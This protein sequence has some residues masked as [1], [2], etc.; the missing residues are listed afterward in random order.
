MPAT[1]IRPRRRGA[2]QPARA[3]ARLPLT[4]GASDGLARVSGGRPL[5]ELVALT[6]ASAVVVG[7]AEN[8]EEPTVAVSGSAGPVPCR[9]GPAA[10]P[11]VAHLVR[12][13]DAELRS[14]PAPADVPA[15]LAEALLIRSAR[16]GET[17]PGRTSEWDGI[18]LTLTAPAADGSRELVAEAGPERAE[19]WFLEILLRSV[20]Q[21]LAG[22]TEPHGAVADLAPAAPDDIATAIE[23]GRRTFVPD[24]ATTTLVAPIEEAV[25]AHADRPAVV[26]GS[27]TLTYREF[28]QAT[29]GVAARLHASGIGRGDRV[30]VL[31]GKSVHAVPAITG[32]LLAGAAY[33]PLDPRSPAPRLAEILDDAACSVV[34]AAPEL[35]TTLPAGLTAPVIDIDIGAAAGAAAG[36]GAGAGAAV[37][38]TAGPDPDDL[39]YVVYTSGS[40]GKPKGVEVR[41]RAVASYVRW[42]VVN[43][44]FD[45]GTRLLQLPSLAFD[46]SVA[47]LFPVLASG[48]LLVLADTHKLLPR[49]LAELAGQHHV[50][51]LTT[52]PSLYRVLLDDLADAA[53]SLHAVTVAG[54]ATTADLARRHHERLPGVRLINEY[55]PTEN[56]V[57]ATAFDHGPDAGPG[58]PIGHVIPNTVATVTGADGRALPAGFVGELRL[59]GHGLADGY[60]NRPDLTAEAFVADA[61]APGGRSYRTG[62]LVWWRPDGMLE[63]AGRADDQVK[64]RGHRVEPGE[65]ESVLA[66]LPGVSQ[67]AVAVVPGPDGAPSLAAWL[68]V[69]DTTVDDIRAGAA[70]ALPPAMVPSSLTLIDDLPRMVSGKIDRGA[71]VRLAG[72]AAPARQHDGPVTGSPAPAACAADDVSLTVAAIFEEVLA[73]GPVHSDADFFDEGGHSLLAISVLDAIEKRLGVAVDLDD[74]FRTPTIRAVT[75]LVREAAPVPGN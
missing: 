57:G 52:V 23:F 11:T 30:A 58:L 44:R 20:S 41:H 25:R 15:A 3:R 42:K 33:V 40:T 66:L 28:W 48:G 49:Q 31:T 53:H 46:S 6:A 9:V 70:A 55:G 63:F 19:A 22:F 38:A 51:H 59:A 73:A 29:Q 47:D 75:E 36:A 13:V 43:H 16:V 60:R 26:A 39:A 12:A 10:L 50:T 54:E 27:D 71:L 7:L 67:V 4:A 5:E 32:T 68:T 17:S 37:P 24:G 18:E 34:L 72:T 8:T 1:T 65:V 56:S 45:T 21:T 62:D 64:I 74:F 61:E 2:S 69:T 14:A 35:R